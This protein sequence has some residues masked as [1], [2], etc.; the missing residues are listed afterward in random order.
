MSRP[1]DWATLNAR[2]PLLAAVPEPARRLARQME[3]AKGARL[4]TCGDRPEA[5]YFVLSGEVHLVRH[6]RNGA[7]IVLQRARDGCLA[8]ASLDHA[9][10]HCDAVATAPSRVLALPMEPFRAALAD[11]VFQARWMAHLAREL[12]RVRTQAERMSLKSAEDRILHYI[13]LEGQDGTVRLARSR[14]DWAAELGLTHEALYRALA[15]MARAGR[16]RMNGLV[17]S[18]AA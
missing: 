16:I 14:K 7:W 13:A 4:F 10:Y 12:R 18:L 17:I 8:E 2:S 9:A 1:L 3:L 5:M 6:G 15:R 11:A